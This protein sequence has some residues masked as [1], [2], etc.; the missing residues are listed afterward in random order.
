VN[1]RVGEGRGGEDKRF[2]LLGVIF[3][4]VLDPY[5]TVK[6]I[7]NSYRLVQVALEKYAFPFFL[8]PVVHPLAKTYAHELPLLLRFVFFV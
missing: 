3:Q 2:A 7:R 8:A 4:R 1:G 6:A 5:R